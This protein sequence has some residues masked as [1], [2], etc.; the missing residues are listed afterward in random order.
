LRAIVHSIHS[1]VPRTVASLD[2]RFETIL[3]LDSHLDVSLGGDDGVYPKELRIIAQRTGVHTALRRISAGPPTLGRMKAGRNQKGGVTV[4]I[5]ERMLSRHA[6]DIELKLPS[7]LRTLDLKESISSVV[8]FLSANTGIE[9]YQSPPKS[10]LSLLP[11]MKKAGPWL[12]DVDVD[13]MR[14][15]QEGCYTQIRNAEPGVLQSM[16]NVVGFI[17]SSTPEIITISE[18]TVSAIRSENSSFSAF[19][20][21]LRLMGYEIEERGIYATD[22]EV[23][24]GI[25]ICKEFYR[26]V[27]MPLMI[28]HMDAMM[29]GDLEGFEKKERIAAKEFFRSKGYAM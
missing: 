20:G 2:E 11:R 6:S 8:D 27:T 22:Q 29:R 26:K 9:V 12:L 25:S 16:S 7:S 24:R 15:M 19:I 17:R 21:S 5:P 23:I 10:L 4:A 13:Y 18:A 28:E 14:E 1:Q 3:S